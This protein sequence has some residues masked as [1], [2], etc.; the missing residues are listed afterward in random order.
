MHWDA[1]AAQLDPSRTVWHLWDGQPAFSQPA[2]H[3]EG[4]APLSPE[5][6]TED[7]SFKPT[8]WGFSL[9]PS[10]PKEL[11]ARYIGGTQKWNATKWAVPEQNRK[12]GLKSGGKDKST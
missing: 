3:P 8:L 10:M 7:I 2:S 5:L 4:R 9:D 6:T 12:W 1:E 11:E